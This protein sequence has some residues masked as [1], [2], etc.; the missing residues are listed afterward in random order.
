M[1]AFDSSLK[2]LG[3]DYLDLY[4]I[5]WPVAGKYRDT[6]K[7][8]E[9][10][11][12]EKRVK[13][14]G[15]SNFLKHHLEDLLSDVD[16]VPMVNQLE[17]HPYLLQQQLQDFCKSHQIQYEAWSPLMQGKAFDIEE[18]QRIA[19]AYDKSVAQL[20]IRWN[21]QKGVI[22]IPKSSNRDRI[23]Q[24]A[25]VFDFMISDEDMKRIDAL[26]RNERVGPDPDNFDF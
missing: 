18:L 7:A 19:Q 3:T 10:L 23:A 6:W 24:N 13:A 17:F 25:D 5:H 12:K 9:Y 20:L 21:L 11:Y 4:L 22:T 8:L 26:D 16:I 1:K 2:K 15:V 14:I